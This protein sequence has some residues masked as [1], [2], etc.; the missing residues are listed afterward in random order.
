[1]AKTGTRKINVKAKL[2]FLDYIPN[3]LLSNRG[4]F[5]LFILWKKYVHI[6]Q[7]INTVNYST[8]TGRL[9]QGTNTAFWDEVR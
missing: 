1:M 9:E 3:G 8:N 6:K 7:L 5:Y 4:F 2:V